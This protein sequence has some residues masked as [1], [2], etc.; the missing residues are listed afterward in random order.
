MQGQDFIKKRAMTGQRN[1]D[2]KVEMLESKSLG[3]SMS[4]VAGFFQ[5]NI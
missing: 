1:N 5:A 4:M 3:T 2:Q